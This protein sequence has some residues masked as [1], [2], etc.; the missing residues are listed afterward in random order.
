MGLEPA[1]TELLLL[2]FTSELYIPYYCGLY[3]YM[4]ISLTKL[5]DF[6]VYTSNIAICF[7]IVIS[8]LESAEI[9]YKHTQQ[10]QNTKKIKIIASGKFIIA[11]LCILA[12]RHTKYTYIYK[13]NIHSFCRRAVRVVYIHISRY[14]Y[15][16]KTILHLNVQFYHSCRDWG[17]IY[18]N[19]IYNSPMYWWWGCMKNWASHQGEPACAARHIVDTA[20]NIIYF[21]SHTHNLYT[22]YIIDVEKLRKFSNSAIIFRKPCVHTYNIHLLSIE[23]RTLLW[24]CLLYSS[25]LHLIPSYWVSLLSV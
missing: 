6:T 25:I 20:L 2:Y 10:Q 1:I 22:F 5:Q 16:S 3:I 18:L 7:L 21:S 12:Y 4:E 24:K 14:I 17:T 15:I 9:L 11:C 19:I 8:K 13:I 23:F